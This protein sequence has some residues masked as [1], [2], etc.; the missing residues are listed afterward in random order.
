M[1]TVGET[2]PLDCNWSGRA[3]GVARACL[4]FPSWNGWGRHS[5]VKKPMALDMHALAETAATL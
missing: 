2:R 4:Y 5:G 3:R 1:K